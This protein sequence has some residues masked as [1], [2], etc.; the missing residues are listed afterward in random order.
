MELKP[1]SKPFNSKCYLSPTANKEKYFKDLKHLVKIEV[2]TPVQHSQYSTLVFI[3]L[4][5]KE[6][7]G[8]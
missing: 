6:L 1:Y 5:R 3:F 2:L 7:R 8:L 4:R